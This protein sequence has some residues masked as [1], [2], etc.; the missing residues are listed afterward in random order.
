MPQLLPIRSQHR[1]LLLFFLLSLFSFSV[2]LPLQ[3]YSDTLARK[4]ALFSSLAYGEPASIAANS[5]Y[6]STC[7]L[8]EFT[9][10]HTYLSPPRARDAFAY[11]G[12]DVKEKLIVVAFKGSNDTEDYIIDIAGPVRY[13][14]PC[15]I[16]G[17][18]LGQTHHGFCAYY[19]SLAVLGLALEVT[20]MWEEKKGEY[21]V[22]VTG[23]SLGGAAATLCAADLGKRFGLS[24]LLYTFGEPRV[25]DADFASSLASHSLGSYRVVHASDCVPHL[26][27]CCG[28]LRKEQC[29]P[30]PDCP[31]HHGQEVW[32]DNSMGEGAPFV[33]CPGD[34][35]E[36]ACTNG[37]VTSVSDHKY[38]FGERLGTWCCFPPLPPDFYST[39][40][41]SSGSDSSSRSVSL[42]GLEMEEKA[43]VSMRVAMKQ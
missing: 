7:Q 31:F 30:K 15:S 24:T 11:I 36:D 43:A 34:E 39:S 9:I 27:P 25:G 41:T 20:R 14:F 40:S 10:L 26:P 33:M 19:R 4:A 2:A 22:L 12:M 23:H 13:R 28:G 3:P 32:Y 6:N 42:N 16:G 21:T 29:H 18:E 37:S 8:P 1:H 17:V 38:Y 35:D 5:I